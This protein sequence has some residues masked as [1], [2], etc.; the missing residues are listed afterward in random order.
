[1][2]R[3]FSV[4][5]IVLSASALH[6]ES[7]PIPTD[8]IPTDA[9]TTQL[10]FANDIVPIFTKLGCNSGGCH[11]KSTG[12]GG[13]KLSLFGFEPADDF[14]AISRGSRGRRVFPASPDES[15]LL[16]KATMAVPHGGGRRME[17]TDP[18]FVLLREWIAAE[19]P[20]G[21]GDAPKI[22]GLRIEPKTP[23][24]ANDVELQLTAAAIYSDGSTRDVTRLTRFRSSDSAVAD[25]DEHGLVHSESRSGETAIVGLYQE[26]AAVSRVI[27]PTANPPNDLQQRL[28]D[29]PIRN[30]IDRHLVTKLK[31]LRVAPASVA[32]DGA[33]LR[34]AT[35]QIAGRL[36]SP[37]ETQAFLASDDSNKREQLIDRLLDSQD[38]ADHFAQKWSDLLR[39]KRR[40]QTP[41]IPGTIAFHRWIRNALASNLPYD[42][43]VR[44]IVTATG[45]VTVNPPAQWYAEVRYLDR[46]VDDTAQV[47]LGLRIGC[48]RCHHHPF[49]K[50]SQ[51][52]YFGLA[53]FFSRVDRKGGAGVAERRADETIFVKATGEV[54]HPLTDAVV[55]ARGLDAPAIELA[56]YADPRHSLVDW[57]SDPDN[58]YFARAF[59]NR[60][61]AHFFGRGLVEPI[62]D[63]RVTNPASIEPLLDEFAAEFVESKFDM[64]Q[65][66]H[67]ICT[68]TT[69]QLSSQANETNLDETQSHSRFYPRRLAAEVL[70]DA[71][72]QVTDVKTGFSGLPSGT[73]AV[74][75]PD[76]DYSNKFLTLFGRPKRESAC[77]CERTAQPSLSQSLFVLNDS[78]LLGKATSSAGYAAKLS[79][80]NRADDEKLRELFLTV[81][82]REPSEQELHD[83]TAY[84]RSEKDVRKAYGNLLWALMSTKEFMYIH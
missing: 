77:E 74:Q 6:A 2:R 53:A 16:K 32:D 63:M 68:S 61:W 58:E 56:P 19:M 51:D 21:R 15:L 34:R 44:E 70:L 48:A 17:T 18:E 24:M 65:V 43:F 50:F 1:M 64:R 7:L 23:L 12:R 52:D 81:F 76:E 75:L 22:T 5:M 11:G 82:S 60:M 31:Q 62:D 35:L 55:V 42:Q 4:L 20:T 33:F 54:K 71:T 79:A 14:D 83:A 25:V 40:G 36:P 80:D 49:E 59:V 73:R 3:T 28:N 13:F 84:I 9:A 10:H 41:R 30:F 27:V 37:A 38:Y 78:F 67:T 46:Y 26:Q 66:I 45:N 29:L 69:Y 47:F 39:N 8:P 72:D 57:M